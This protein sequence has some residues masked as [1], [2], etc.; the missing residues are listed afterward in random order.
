MT[1]SGG[2]LL[3]DFPRIDPGQR[4]LIETGPYRDAVTALRRW[5]NWPE[6]QLALSGAPAAGKTRLL[7]WWAAETGAAMI[8]SAALVGADMD[9]I[10]RLSVS[11][12]A[13]DDAHAPGDGR[14]LLAVLNL[15]RD[16]GAPVLLGGQGEP[17]GWV[18]QPPD[19][20]SRLRAMPVARI[21]DPDDE[22]L[23]LRLREECARRHLILPDESVVYLSQRMERSWAAVGLVADQ[24]ERTK[25][26]AETKPSA[27][28]VLIALGM[29][30]G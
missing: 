10:A 15:C 21:E 23:A 26:R 29:D 8:T 13:V 9:D 4:P 16:S 28:A 27:R 20:N 25:G 7:R 24:I 11:A 3:L 17:G 18:L 2:Q 14:A 22:T 12:L 5:K 1:D 30:P 6:H 19:L